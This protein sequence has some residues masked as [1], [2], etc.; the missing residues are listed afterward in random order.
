MNKYITDQGGQDG[1]KARPHPG[2]MASQARHNMDA[3][4]WTF[5]PRIVVPRGEGE[6]SPVSRRF[7][8][9]CAVC[10]SLLDFGFK[11][12]YAVST[13]DK[14]TELRLLQAQRRFGR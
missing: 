6:P 10:P 13:P 8:S 14:A 11:D 5:A 12:H 1:E 9:V 7:G 2:P 3:P 4:I